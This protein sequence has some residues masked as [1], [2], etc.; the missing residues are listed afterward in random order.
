MTCQIEES[1]LLN[2][3]DINEILRKI[4]YSR[5]EDPID[6]CIENLDEFKDLREW[7]NQHYKIVEKKLNELEI[8]WTPN[9]LNG[10][11]CLISLIY[12]GKKFFI[13]WY[14]EY[15]NS[16][17]FVNIFNPNRS[18]FYSFMNVEL[19]NQNIINKLNEYV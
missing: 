3:P 14:P 5:R 15:I 17:V 10:L 19:F 7:S 6:V 11:N 8:K 12:K 2:I 13:E 18:K 16:G 4:D 1:E 9:K